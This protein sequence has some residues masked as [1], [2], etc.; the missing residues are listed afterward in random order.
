[1]VEGQALRL[2]EPMTGTRAVQVTRL[3]WLLSGLALQKED[4]TWMESKD[5]FAYLSAGGGR[6]TAKVS[7]VPAGEYKGIRFRIGVDES[8]NKSDPNDYPPG[9]ALN[10]QVN[11]LHWGWQGGYIFMAI[12]G[13]FTQGGKENGFSSVS[14]THLHPLASECFGR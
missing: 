14:Y 8:T 1:M 13:R 9:H 11:G 6:Q 3:D 7:G 4:G 12:E 5:W 2:G 10:P